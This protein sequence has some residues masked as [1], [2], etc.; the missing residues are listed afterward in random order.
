MLLVLLLLLVFGCDEVP[1]EREIAASAPPEAR[2][3]KYGT[4]VLLGPSTSRAAAL[5][6]RKSAGARAQARK[7]Q[8][9]KEGD[10]TGRD[11]KRE[12]L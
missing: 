9:K 8:C 3:E 5:P 12:I 4:E 6:G 7:T 11:R 2:P 1:A 10:R